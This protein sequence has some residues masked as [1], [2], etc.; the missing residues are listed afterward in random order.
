[1]IFLKPLQTSGTRSWRSCGE[2]YVRIS[3]TSSAVLNTRDVTSSRL[4]VGSVTWIVTMS[5]STRPRYVGWVSRLCASI[6]RFRLLSVSCP[7]ATSRWRSCAVSM[8]RYA[9]AEP[10]KLVLSHSQ[11]GDQPPDHL[12]MLVCGTEAKLDC[13]RKVLKAVCRCGI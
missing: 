3:S 1:M 4:Y 11:S 6:K 2:R 12:W 10:L 13:W 5:P 7:S 9:L 8:A